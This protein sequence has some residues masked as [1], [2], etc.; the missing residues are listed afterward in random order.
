MKLTN[1][2]HVTDK[3]NGKM[4]GFASLSSN[5]NR[6]CDRMSKV[7]G[8]ICE[9]CYASRMKKC[10]KDLNNVL[11]KNTE[12]ISKQDLQWEQ[13]NY[14]YFRLQAFGDLENQKT[15]E[16]YFNLCNSNKHVKFTLWTK[17][18][19]LVNKVIKKIGK[20]KNLILIRS[21]VKINKPNKLPLNFDKVFTV[22]SKDYIKQNK[23]KINCGAK[24]CLS[25]R[26]CYDKNKT[27]F[28]NEVLKGK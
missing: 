9:K 2:L 24:K 25:C 22:Y 21:S 10:Y 5:S 14:A 19:E 20:P 28:V 6:F 7:K 26:L 13:L 8:S 18:P 4:K 27:V 11:N 23:I 15:V 1:G 3:M 17:R 12:I 16:N